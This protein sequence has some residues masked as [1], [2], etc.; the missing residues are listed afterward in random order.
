MEHEEAIS[1]TLV[2]EDVQS[3]ALKCY[4][5]DSQT[6]FQLPNWGLRFVL[7]VEENISSDVVLWIWYSSKWGWAT[8]SAQSYSL[9]KQS[10]LQEQL[11]IWN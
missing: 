1:V 6:N 3:Q 10:V 11:L 7:N 5:L 2:C 8:S 9:D 4:F